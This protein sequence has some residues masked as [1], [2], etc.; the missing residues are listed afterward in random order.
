[1]K[2]YKVDV[3]TKTPLKGNPAA[4]VLDEFDEE[5]ML[6]IASELNMSETVFVRKDGDN[7]HLRFFTPTAEIPL[8]GHATIAAFYILKLRG[9][10]SEY[11][12]AIT[13]AGEISVRV[14]DKI[15]LQ[16]SRAEI[17]GELDES[18]LRKSLGVHL[19]DAMAVTVGLNVG[20]AEVSSFEE[21]MN[22]S[23]DFHMLADYCRERQIAGVHMFTLD[24]KYDA[25]ARFF[26]PAIGVPEDPVTGTANAALAYYLRQTGKL[27]RD[28][29]AFEQG[30]ALRREGVAHVRLENGIWVGGDAVCV[31]EGNLKL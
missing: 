16:T 29:Y 24:S 1:M 15:W 26:C 18:I 20:I 6:A 10:V 21:L 28:E 31:L 25:A 22:I 2:V 23:P 11:C 27:L 8:C 30:H 19:R 9:I 13:K 7:F 12:K 3:F 17:T 14:A 5:K 4:V